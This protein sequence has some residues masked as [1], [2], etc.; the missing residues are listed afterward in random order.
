LAS[1][2]AHALSAF[3]IGKV[4][5]KVL[6][7]KK[8]FVL[9]ILSAIMPDAD[10]IAFRFGIPYEHMFGHRGIS[11]SLFF[12]AIWA[13]LLIVLFHAKADRRSKKTIYVYYLIATASHGI[14]DGLTTGGRG[15]A[16]F[17]PFFSDRYFLPWKLIQVSPLSIE[18]F[19]SEWG[20]KV[21]M[22]EA[23]W[24]GIPSIVLIAIGVYLNRP[25]T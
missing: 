10:V 1:A 4:F 22:S 12:A 17:A 23:I 11:H 7:N 16:Y 20:V 14:L 5:P 8:I 2:F 21:I 13:F 25:R 18:R 15:I 19:F 24:V 9:G 3:A 6:M